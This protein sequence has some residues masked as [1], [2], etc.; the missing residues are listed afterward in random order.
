MLELDLSS[1][2]P[3]LSP[4]QLWLIHYW[5]GEYVLLLDVDTY[6]AAFDWWKQRASG[7]TVDLSDLFIDSQYRYFRDL[8]TLIQDTDRA[9]HEKDFLELFLISILN[10][11]EGT[12]RSGYYL[13]DLADSYLSKYPESPFT[14][15]VQNYIHVDL[16]PLLWAIGYSI[17]LVGARPFGN[18]SDYFPF[19]VGFGIEMPVSYR[20]IVLTPSISW[21]WGSVKTSFSY[22]GEGWDDLFTAFTLDLSLGYRV[23]LSPS[24]AVLPHGGMGVLRLWER[25]PQN[26]KGEFGYTPIVSLGIVFEFLMH[27]IQAL[28]STSAEWLLEWAID[29]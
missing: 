19:Q 4:Y 28:A 14:R 24:F 12:F 7:V 29:D 16:P 21:A 9:P 15:F 17:M 5:R 13:N 22:D 25:P 26:E 23:E 10:Q 1:F 6:A 11:G 3:S 2:G 18:I 27:H 20:S 8:V